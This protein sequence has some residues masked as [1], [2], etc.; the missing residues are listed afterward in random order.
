[1]ISVKAKI[2]REAYEK[3]ESNVFY[4]FLQLSK[5]ETFTWWSGSF[6]GS[7]PCKCYFLQ[8]HKCRA[9][10]FSLYQYTQIKIKKKT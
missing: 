7:A 2:C 5:G 3:K 6:L 1:M 10:F 9:Q 4:K 8:W